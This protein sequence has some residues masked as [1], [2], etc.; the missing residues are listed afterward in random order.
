MV[1]TPILILK[2]KKKAAEECDEVL[3]MLR[4]ILKRL[5]NSADMSLEARATYYRDDLEQVVDEEDDW[6]GLWCR[7]SRGERSWQMMVLVVLMNEI[8][9]CRRIPICRSWVWASIKRRWSSK[10]EK[11]KTEQVKITKEGNVV[12]TSASLTMLAYVYCLEP[13]KRS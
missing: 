1:W 9:N 3:V 5:I 13:S 10:K 12:R 2:K 8:E 6:L 7:W 4:A 11:G